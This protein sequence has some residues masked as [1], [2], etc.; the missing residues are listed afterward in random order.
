MKGTII[1]ILSRI[2][3]HS[4]SAAL[5]AALACFLYAT[6]Y[7]TLVDFSEGSSKSVIF[8]SFFKNCLQFGRKRRRRSLV[9]NHL[10]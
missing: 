2:I 7:Y 5:L 9:D 4:F 3:L 8:I 6:F 1:R 10:K